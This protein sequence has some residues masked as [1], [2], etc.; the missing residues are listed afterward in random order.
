MNIQSLFCI[1]ALSLPCY[2]YAEIQNTTSPNA[3]KPLTDVRVSMQRMLKSPEGRY[4]LNLYAGVTKP[5][6][7]LYDQ[8]ENKKVSFKGTQKGDQ[9]AMDSFK[10]ELDSVAYGPMQLTG[11]L[12]ANTGIFNTELVSIQNNLVSRVQFEPAFK[13]MNKPLF[14]FKFYGVKADTQAQEQLLTRVDVVN[15][16]TKA[17]TQTLTGFSAYPNSVGYMDINFDGYYDIILSDLSQ[18]RKVEDKRYIYWMY[19]PK[20]QQFQR[21]KQLEK[22]IGFPNLNGEKQQI[23]FGAGQ[24]FQVKNGLL[25]KV[26]EE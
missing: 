11:V 7:T 5:H 13:V 19:N 17:V 24:L 25:N 8:I 4:F 21:S 10:T 14:V 9:I 18:D 22:I 1:A 23:D 2:A 6:A 15:K 16:T 12:N 26:L 20:T 3:L